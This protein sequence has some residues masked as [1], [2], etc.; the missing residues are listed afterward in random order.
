MGYGEDLRL[1]NGQSAV[2]LPKGDF[3]MKQ[4]I[5]KEIYQ[6]MV[7]NRFP[8]Q[9]ITVMKFTRIVDHCIIRC[10]LCNKEVEIAAD[11][12]YKI[13]GDY[14][15][16][17][18]CN[19]EKNKNKQECL[20][21]IGKNANLKFVSFSKLN[22]GQRR[23][24]V[25]CTVC[26]NT[27]TKNIK[28]IIRHP[29]CGVCASISKQTK[30]NEQFMDDI[31]GLELKNLEEY[32]GAYDKLLFGCDVCGFKWRTTPH[33]ILT[34][35]GC[36]KCNRFTSKGEKGIKTTLEK[37]N[38][39]YTWQATFEWTGKKRY[40]YDFYI[41]EINTL[42]E[43]NGKQ[44]YEEVEFFRQSLEEVQVSDKIKQELAIANGYNFLVIPYWQQKEIGNI[45]QRLFREEVHSSEWKGETSR[46]DGDIV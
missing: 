1:K 8:K 32:T 19:P 46:R 24:T 43:F 9:K 33:A 41:P 2:I 34:G 12:F 4:T 42:I 35:C 37:L 18:C 45:I 29:Y 6:R 23:A 5:D 16:N 44:H 26:G 15:T 20:E 27:F 38:K 10:G 36:P 22:T 21:A 14:L 25:L 40:R 30:T 3:I 7:D 28:E 17:K 11:S 39:V 13:R 31:R